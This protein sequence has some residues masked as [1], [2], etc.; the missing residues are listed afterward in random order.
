MFNLDH[1]INIIAYFYCIQYANKVHNYSEVQVIS[2][3]DAF[4]RTQSTTGNETNTG[5]QFDIKY[6]LKL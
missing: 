1:S 5:F 2:S 6:E 4:R 3:V